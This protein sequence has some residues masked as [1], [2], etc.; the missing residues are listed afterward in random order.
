MVTVTVITLYST[1]YRTWLWE[2]CTWVVSCRY[3]VLVCFGSNSCVCISIPRSPSDRRSLE[4]PLSGYACTCAR[5]RTRVEQKCPACAYTHSG[6]RDI[7]QSEPSTQYCTAVPQ[8]KGRVG[9]PPKSDAA[10][11]L[12]RL[13]ATRALCSATFSFWIRAFKT[14]S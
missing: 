1:R 11:A 5:H 14:S 7:Q 8:T 4:H 3:R 12:K 9:G 2:V 6:S 10:S 13:C